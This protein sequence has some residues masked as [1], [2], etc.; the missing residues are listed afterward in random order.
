MKVFKAKDLN[1][2][3]ELAIRNQ[4]KRQHQNIHNSYQDPCQR[5]F[6][7]IEPDS[8]IRPHRHSNTG[9]EEL[10]IG[11][12]GKLALIVFDDLGSITEVIRFGSLNSS[13]QFAVGAEVQPDKWHTVISLEK[14]SVLLEVKAGPFNPNAAKEFSEW[15]PSESSGEAENYLKELISSANQI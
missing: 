12:R 2:L 4:R 15:A 11:I 8:Y 10:L 6:N 3:S 9:G 14:G 1:D 7:A 5:F 13:D